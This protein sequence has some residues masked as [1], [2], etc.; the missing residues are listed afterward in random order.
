MLLIVIVVISILFVWPGTLDLFLGSENSK[1]V[2]NFINIFK[3]NQSSVEIPQIEYGQGQT[4]SNQESISSNVIQNLEEDLFGNGIR[5]NGSEGNGSGTIKS[6]I[7]NLGEKVISLDMVKNQD[8]SMVFYYE[9]FSNNS[10]LVNITILDENKDIIYSENFQ[11]SIFDVTID[12]ISNNSE[13]IELLI[14]HKDF[15]ILSAILFNTDSNIDT[16]IVFRDKVS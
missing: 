13:S 15:G 3:N 12:G 9:D 10:I 11:T 2:K 14:K 8:N 6:P 4:S 5:N 16:T 7:P 1:N